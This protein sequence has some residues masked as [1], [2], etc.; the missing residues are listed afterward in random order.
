MVMGEFDERDE[1]DLFGFVGQ[2]AESSA[3]APGDDIDET[4]SPT[5]TNTS[6]NRF[7]VKREHRN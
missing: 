1:S 2:F 4:I 6:R 7:F 5:T 3:A